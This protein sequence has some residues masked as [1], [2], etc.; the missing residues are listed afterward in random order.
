MPRTNIL[1]LLQALKLHGMAGAFADLSCQTSITPEKMLEHLLTAE[2]ADR[3][4]RSI[5][6]QMD[7]AKFPIQRD[8]DTFAFEESILE[9]RHLR[10]LADGQFIMDKRNLIFVGGTGTDKTHL[11]IALARQAV[12]NHKKARFYNAVDL[13]NRLEQEKTLEKISSFANQFKNIDVLV[14]DELGY[15]PFSQAGGALLFHLISR[16]YE[17]LSII[18]TTNLSF[19][20]WSQVFGD[21]KITT[22]MLDRLTH[23][24]DILE[25]GNDSFRFKTRTNSMKT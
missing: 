11:A 16:L 14:L 25:T 20:E 13:V 15:L 8:L 19:A 5:N 7:C 18:I 6:Y 17:K 22:A 24:C 2:Q 21:P 9:E 4:A 10:I 12:R 23:H 3:K 1:A